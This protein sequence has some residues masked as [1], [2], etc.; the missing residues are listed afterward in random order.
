MGAVRGKGWTRERDG[1]LRDLAAKELSARQ[2]ATKMGLSNVLVSKRIKKLG[3]REVT[4]PKAPPQ[5]SHIINYK[6]ARRGFHVPG[7]L[8]NQ[9]FDL[10]RSGVSIAEACR[11][12][13]INVHAPAHR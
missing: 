12:L 6:R 8:E 10:I 11:R 9:Y 3:L 5:P 1:I 2:I 7:H 13:E 4:E